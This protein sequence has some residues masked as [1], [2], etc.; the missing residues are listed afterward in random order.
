MPTPKAT[1]KPASPA[2]TFDR[3]D[4]LSVGEI[5]EALGFNISVGK[6]S[7]LGLYPDLTVL[8]A[9]LYR[10]ERLAEIIRCLMADLAKRLANIAAS[11]PKATT[12]AT[13]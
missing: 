4:F 1:P 11:A 3:T 8:N 2:A 7:S 10:R 5:N 12:E 6:L 13:S 9:T